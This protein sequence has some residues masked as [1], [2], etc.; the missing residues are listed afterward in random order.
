VDPA[1]AAAFTEY[2]RT[3]GNR[4]AKAFAVR[5][6]CFATLAKPTSLS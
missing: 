6:R 3:L 5:L 4:T 2:H 1:A